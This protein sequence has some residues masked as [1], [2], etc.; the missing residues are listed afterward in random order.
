V[1]TRQWVVRTFAVAAVALGMLWPA[2]W[3]GGPFFFPDSRTY[4]RGADAAMTRL[5][6]RPTPWTASADGAPNVQQPAVVDERALHNQSEARTRTVEEISK[7]GIILGRSPFYG[8]LLYAGAVTGG[9]WLTMALQ[10]A[11]VLL[12]AW[13]LLRA[14]ALP[15]W[16]NLALA[17]LALCLVP[18]SSFF[19]CYLMPDVFAGIGLLACAVLL[20]KAQLTRVDYALWFALLAAA[21][22]FHDSCTLTGAVLLALAVA[23]NLLLRSWT[24]WRG[25]C[26]LTLACAVAWA[27][28]AVVAAGIQHASGRPA[29]RLPFVSARLIADGPGTN[30]LRATCPASGFVLCDYVQEF[31]LLDAEFLFGTEPG[32]SVFE[33]APYEKRLAISREQLRFILA[34]LRY[35]PVGVLKSGLRN[36]AAEF[37][38]LRLIAFHYDPGMK[39][40]MDRTFPLPVLG[41]VQASQ[42]YRGTLPI[43]ALT[44]LMYAL[45]IAS[46]GLLA[47]MLWRRRKASAVQSALG[48]IAAWALVGVAVNASICGAISTVDPRYQVRVVWVLPLLAVA[49]AMQQRTAR[50]RVSASA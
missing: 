6:H 31:P 18:S 41:G 49:A 9:F 42:A 26:A 43:A 37:C 50:E 20:A 15:A 22:L 11:A 40:T 48:A 10:A 21:M 1:E 35:D 3:N 46:L 29:L 28:Q 5:T 39:Q 13:L 4:L 8:L 24:N 33:V 30:Y 47:A 23:W 45:V 38:D 44:A 12:A 2:F 34:V 14:L 36:A 7:K 25:L 32:R 27:G 19:V 17:G 16:P